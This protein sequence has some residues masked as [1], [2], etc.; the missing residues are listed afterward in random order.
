MDTNKK[1][2][3]ANEKLNKKLEAIESKINGGAPGGE[4]KKDENNHWDDNGS[5]WDNVQSF[6][7][8]R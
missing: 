7:K 2:L 1:M 6:F 3:E 4:T 5:G 8:G